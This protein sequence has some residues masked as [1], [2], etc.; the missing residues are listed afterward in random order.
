[1]FV[2]LPSFLVPDRRPIWD[3]GPVAAA[4]AQ[5]IAS[6]YAVDPQHARRV[7]YPF[8]NQYQ[9]LSEPVAMD[10]FPLYMP[11][12]NRET[13]MNECVDIFTHSFISRGTTSTSQDAHRKN[14]KMVIAA[15]G[16]GIGQPPH[17]LVSVNCQSPLGTC[18]Y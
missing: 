1:M 15:G 5:Q 7:S 8:L 12:V 4:S 16:P 2:C 13:Q 6:C 17:I 14:Y 11:F 3:G 10:D 9:S 18:L